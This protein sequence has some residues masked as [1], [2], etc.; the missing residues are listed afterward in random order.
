MK[1][2]IAF[3]VFIVLSF[4][5]FA[6]VENLDKPVKG[7]WDFQLKKIWEVESAGADVLAE[8]QDIKTSRDGTVYVA[9]SKHCLIYIFDKDGKY[10][11]SFGKV[12]EGPG[13]VMNYQSGNQLFF[14][15]DTVIFASMGKIQYYFLDGKYK[16]TAIIPPTLKPSAFL[17][18]DVFISAPPSSL[19]NKPGS[20]KMVMYNVKDKSQKV[21]SEF[22][23]FKNIVHSMESEGRGQRVRIVIPTVTPVMCVNAG[24]GKVYY[25]MND[26]YKIHFFDSKTNATG[27]FGI[28]G[29]EPLLVSKEF[30]NMIEQSLNDLPP[31]VVKNTIKGFPKHATYYWALNVLKNGLVFA[32]LSNPNDASVQAIDIF[33]PTGEYLYSSTLTIGKDNQLGIFHFDG[34]FLYFYMRDEADVLKLVKNSIKMP[35]L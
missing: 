21:I 27:F 31:E 8:I 10:I 33:S 4:S 23:P 2:I 28:K 26:V 11:S 15:D 20:V 32:Y 19:G 18:K 12:G 34:D 13:E 14:A 1:C 24:N 22:M 35:V 6:Q 25:G 29:R 9:E 3:L 7:N 16:G 17:S 5:L 30:L